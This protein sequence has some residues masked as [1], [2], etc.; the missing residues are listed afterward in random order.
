MRGNGGPRR[1][2][3]SNRDDGPNEHGASA[4]QGRC[5]TP[6]LAQLS[7]EHLSFLLP[8]G[9]YLTTSARSR[10]RMPLTNRQPRRQS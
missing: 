2:S 3:R 4:R 10:T 6:S 5:T 7:D 9:G 8:L 1:A